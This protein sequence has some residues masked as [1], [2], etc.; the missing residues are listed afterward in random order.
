MQINLRA[1]PEMETWLRA[2]NQRTGKSMTAII[3]EAI[4]E[5]A[6]GRGVTISTQGAIYTPAIQDPYRHHLRRSAHQN[7][8][9]VDKTEG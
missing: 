9:K 6:A 5:Y 7:K 8:K 1:N 4:S 2:E 3:R